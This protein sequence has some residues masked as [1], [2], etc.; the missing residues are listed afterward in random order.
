VIMID[1]I[2]RWLGTRRK[3]ELTPSAPQD[4]PV[5]EIAV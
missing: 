2:S 4:E 3:P 1:S 5:P